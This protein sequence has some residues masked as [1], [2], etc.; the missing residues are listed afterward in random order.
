VSAAA[1]STPYTSLADAHSGQR[2]APFLAGLPHLCLGVVISLDLFIRSTT[3]DQRS[4]PLN[5]S[6]FLLVFPFLVASLLIFIYARRRNAPLWTA[7]WDG[8]F[9]FLA[10]TISATLLAALDEDT[11]A[12]QMGFAFLGMLA[13]LIGY[14]LRFRYAPRHALLMAFL[15]LPFSAL[16]FLDTV[17]LFHQGVFVLGLYLLYAVLAA[18]VV[19]SPGWIAAVS[20]AFI[21]S[22][23]AGVVQAMVFIAYSITPAT[24]VSLQDGAISAFW[25]QSALTSLFYFAPWLLWKL[26]DFLFREAK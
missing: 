11:A 6:P 26:R 8:Y 23:A 3:P 16:I 17:P 21:A 20:V 4:L 1:R 13:L 24:S 14:I 19:I 22:L 25:V 15:L 7:S 9:I 5:R 12:L 10:S 2:W 18:W